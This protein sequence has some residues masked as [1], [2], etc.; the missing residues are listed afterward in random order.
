MRGAGCLRWARILSDDSIVLGWNRRRLRC[1][2]DCI[3]E[4][5]SYTLDASPVPRLLWQC[6]GELHLLYAYCTEQSL[7]IHT[8][9]IKV[10]GRKACFHGKFVGAGQP[11]CCPADGIALADQSIKEELAQS[12]WH[13]LSTR[14]RSCKGL[15]FLVAG[16]GVIPFIIIAP[17]LSASIQFDYLSPR[18]TCVL[19][20]QLLAVASWAS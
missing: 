16:L 9:S 17:E 7:S 15:V 12:C 20:P 13:K 4:S 19:Y 10:P 2:S 6:E 8:S 11:S 18:Y 5:F 3:G 14:T 1:G